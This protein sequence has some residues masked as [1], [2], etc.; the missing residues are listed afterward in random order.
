MLLAILTLSACGPGVSSGPPPARKSEAPS[1]SAEMVR[2]IEVERALRAKAE[3]L[4]EKQEASTG[5]YQNLSLIIS[6]GL[7]VALV[8]GTIL[9]SQARHEAGKQ[10]DSQ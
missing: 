7:V 6:A 2:Q 10:P 1:S 8:V 5:R 3:S 4:L 9:G